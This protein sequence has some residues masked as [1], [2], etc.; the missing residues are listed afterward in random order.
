MT[1]IVNLFAPVGGSRTLRARPSSRADAEGANSDA[2]ELLYGLFNLVPPTEPL[3]PALVPRDS[4]LLIALGVT[5]ELDA[6]RIDAAVQVLLTAGML[7]AVVV[8]QQRHLVLYGD[9]PALDASTGELRERPASQSA[10]PI[11]AAIAQTTQTTSTEALEAQVFQLQVQLDTERE[12]GLL[13]RSAIVIAAL[14]GLAAL[15]Q[16][17]LWFWV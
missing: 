15:R 16:A 11:P 14:I 2:R 3:A 9:L 13:L 6:A 4:H 8:G 7:R 1:K 17:A 12:R 5:G 10:Q